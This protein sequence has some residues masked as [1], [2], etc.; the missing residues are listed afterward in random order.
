MKKYS[1]LFI[2]FLFLFICGCEKK[3][4][5]IPG[6]DIKQKE[7]ELK[8]KELKLKEE[9]LIRKKDSILNERENKLNQHSSKKKIDLSGN[10]SGT[11]KDGTYWDLFITS[12]QGESFRGY[13]VVYWKSIPRGY[14][15]NFSGTYDPGTQEIVMNEDPETKGA[16]KFTGR[17][18]SD[19]NNMSGSWR[20]YSDGQSFTWELVRSND[21]D[22]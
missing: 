13:N 9:E 11:I 17:I 7:M 21:P 10:Y 22:E 19:G 3:A 15:T 2:L 16:G 6:T 8:E 1:Y 12:T 18:S 20:R 5:D 14:R 4:N